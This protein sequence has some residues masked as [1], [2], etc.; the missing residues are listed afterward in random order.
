MQP[1]HK[2][3]WYSSCRL[4]FSL[5]QQQEDSMRTLAIARKT[6]IE[7]IRD[8]IT[9]ALLVIFPMLLIL[10][11]SSIYGNSNSGFSGYIHIMVCNEDHQGTS[12]T[13]LLQTL[14]DAKLDNKPI[15]TLTEIPNQSD[16]QILLQ[17]HRISLLVV[18]PSD[19]S[20]RLIHSQGTEANVAQV[21]L[22]G[23]KTSNDYIFARGFIDQITSQL[24]VEA[25][26][27]SPPVNYNYTFLPGTGTASDFDLA[28]GGLI[29]F[30]L[31]LLVVATAQILVHE[32][33][34]GGIRRLFLS[35]VKSSEL[36]PGIML[37]IGLFALILI[38]LLFG[39][40]M[41]LGFHSKGNLLLA[42]AIG[43][44]LSI[45]IV[46][47]GLIVASFIKSDGE[48]ANI[49][50]AV[51]VIMVM[52]S[53]GLFPIPDA[54]LFTIV[55]HN[56]QPYEIFPTWHA[57]VAFTKIMVRGVGIGDLLYEFS[58][59]TLLSIVFL[60]IGIFCYQRFRLRNA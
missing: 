18:I 23:D 47:L 42:M 58:A 15:F 49:G 35:G 28:V 2:M 27:I 43:L 6:I 9:L 24:V 53:G 59:L 17:E 1:N 51:G 33:Q 8:P 34:G 19:F 13:S 22:I 45:A 11:Y 29:T 37:A 7:Q 32:Q 46:G 41:L 57:N 10:L 55:G 14:R 39:F 5:L 4:Q 38:P 26:G 25:T 40:S 52:L 54:T 3:A 20:E 36:L 50:G 12:G 44:L 16:A 56:F 30:G 21:N 60:C 31:I 48:A